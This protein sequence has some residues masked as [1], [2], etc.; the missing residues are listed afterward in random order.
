MPNRPALQSDLFMPDEAAS[1]LRSN[2]R[3]LE[4]WRTVGGGPAYVK[5]GRRVAYSRA[6][7]DRYIEQ[8]TRRNT[9][10]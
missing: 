3:T 5:V 9:A 2:P 10:A 8:Q 1:Y 7:L 6:S 4:R